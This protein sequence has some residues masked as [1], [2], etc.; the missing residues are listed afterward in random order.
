MYGTIYLNICLDRPENEIILKNYS[1]FGD[2]PGGRHHAYETYM[3]V[4]TPRAH[5]IYIHGGYD[6]TIEADS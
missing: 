6:E 2:N 1:G 4:G 5:Y 3:P